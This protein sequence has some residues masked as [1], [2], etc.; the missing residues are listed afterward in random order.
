MSGV[1]NYKELDR[2]ILDSRNENIMK[3]A[4]VTPIRPT[5]VSNVV[6]DVYAESVGISFIDNI[7]FVKYKAIDDSYIYL[8][9]K[10]KGNIIYL[11]SD[12][13]Y[14]IYPTIINLNR[15]KLINKEE[16]LPEIPIINKSYKS[17]AFNDGYEIILGELIPFYSYYMSDAKSIETL[18]RLNDS[19]YLNNNF[20]ALL[21]ITVHQIT[22]PSGKKIRDYSLKFSKE[23][24]LNAEL[25]FVSESAN[26]KTTGFTM[27]KTLI[28]NIFY[29][30]NQI[31]KENATR[32]IR[33][34]TE[35]N[36]LFEE[37]SISEVDYLMLTEFINSLTVPY[38]VDWDKLNNSNEYFTKLHKSLCEIYEK[39]QKCQCEVKK[40]RDNV[41]STGEGILNRKPQY[42][43]GTVTTNLIY[44]SL[45][46]T[47]I[48]VGGTGSTINT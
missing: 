14:E 4:H 46:S 36:N 11:H 26:R 28:K 45:F 16:I 35:I 23:L 19:L 41:K 6:G 5:M 1:N 30:S 42:T 25:A 48:T 8:I 40:T 33:K 12:I 27:I 31:Y 47:P 37:P 15:K 22:V 17:Y 18:P 44:D 24:L 20:F 38:Y 2:I 21:P 32:I 7:I 43:Y 13:V 34:L 10:P 3:F 9:I 29:G 39:A